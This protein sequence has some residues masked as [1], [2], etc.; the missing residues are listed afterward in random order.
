MKRLLK[1]ATFLSGAG[2][3][4]TISGVVAYR[5]P[6]TKILDGIFGDGTGESI[7]TFMTSFIGVL[8]IFGIGKGR[9]DAERKPPLS[10]R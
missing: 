1:S 2:A 7:F 10:K 9:L 8:G 5:D 3:I 6:L 4:A